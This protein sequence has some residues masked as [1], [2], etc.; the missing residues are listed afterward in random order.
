MADQIDVSQEIVQT[1]WQKPGKNLISQV[2][3]QV[4][5][6]KP[7]KN[8]VS[9]FFIQVE[10]IGCDIILPSVTQEEIDASYY[11]GMG[12][13]NFSGGVKEPQIWRY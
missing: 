11:S 2:P 5:W 9:Q 8:L 13:F 1:E 10:W 12:D 3:T 4:E 6:Q 7:G